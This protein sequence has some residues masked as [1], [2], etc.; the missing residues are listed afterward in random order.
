ME[1]TETNWRF[2]PAKMRTIRNQKGRSLMQTAAAAGLTLDTV[3]K[4]ETGKVDP[5]VGTIA[6]IANALLVEPTAFFT[7]EATA[8]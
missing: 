1:T 2:D 5:K 8:S 6:R 4:I 3:Q 7:E